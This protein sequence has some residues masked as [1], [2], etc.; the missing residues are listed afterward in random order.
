MGL[1]QAALQAPDEPVR[2]ERTEAMS[3]RT[4]L[5]LIL[6]EDDLDLVCAILDTDRPDHERPLNVYLGRPAVVMATWDELASTQVVL[7]R[8]A[9][10]NVRL[11]FFAHTEASSAYGACI[12]IAAGDVFVALPAYDETFQPAVPLDWDGPVIKRSHLADCERT[13]RASDIHRFQEARKVL[14]E[15]LFGVVNPEEEGLY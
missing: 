1:N 9:D 14:F 13:G 12:W 10:C 11:D 2:P 15:E 5:T 3:H 4:T 6:R 7:E 8:L